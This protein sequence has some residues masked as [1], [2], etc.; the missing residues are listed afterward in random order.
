ML[1]EPGPSLQH[2][3]SSLVASDLLIPSYPST[4]SPYAY[5]LTLHQ[6]PFAAPLPSF[7]LHLA[8]PHQAFLI[9]YI[10]R[11]KKFSRCPLAMTMTMKRPSFNI[12]P[13]RHHGH[14]APVS[15]GRGRVIDRR[16]G[17]RGMESRRSGRSP[18]WKTR[19]TEKER[20]NKTCYSNHAR[21]Q[22]DAYTSRVAERL[23]RSLLDEE[24]FPSSTIA[25]SLVPPCSW[26]PFPCPALPPQ[27]CLPKDRPR[28]RR[29]L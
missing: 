19:I 14:C 7:G 13:R 1:C 27:R 4:C 5:L 15:E 8:P 2:L 10:A 9:R 23:S 21:S 26:A 6:P 3:G 11:A 16:L 24:V 25:S 22:R 28:S 29:R 12:D 18:S 17:L 20:T